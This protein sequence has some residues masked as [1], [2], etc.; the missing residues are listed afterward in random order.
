M[1]NRRHEY[2]F[3][4]LRTMELKLQRNIFTEKSTIGT[5]FIN[6]VAECFILED[7]DRGLNDAMPLSKIND[8]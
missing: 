5:L 6:G 1:T 4:E 3:K 2:L 7:K 8:L